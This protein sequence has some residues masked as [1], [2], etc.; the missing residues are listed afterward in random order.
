MRG[1]G[2]IDIVFFDLN[3]DLLEILDLWQ[4]GV[5]LKRI[6]ALKLI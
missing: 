3:Y 5:A 1:K 4:S 2:S 6:R